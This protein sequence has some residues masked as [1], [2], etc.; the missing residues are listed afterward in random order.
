MFESTGERSF[1]D[2]TTRIRYSVIHSIIIP[3]LFIAGCLFVTMG[4]AYDVGQGIPL[5]TDRFDS[6]EQLDDLVVG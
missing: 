4:L 2:I 1:A 6:L 5:I 3:S